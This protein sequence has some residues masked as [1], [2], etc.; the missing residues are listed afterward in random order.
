MA[1]YTARSIKNKGGKI[2]LEEWVASQRWENEEEAHE[3]YNLGHLYEAA[4]AHYQATGKKNL[5]KIALKSAELVLKDFGPGKVMLPPGHQEIEIGLVKLY[6][7]TGEK[8]YLD[9]AK[10]F[11]D[12]RGNSQGHKLYGFY[13]QDHL[14]VTAD[15]SGWT[16]GPGR[17]YVFGDGRGSGL[18]TGDEAYR[19][20][21]IKL[22][23]DVAFRKMY[24]TG[25]IGSTGAWEGFGRPI[26][27]PTVQLIVKLCF[28]CQCF[29]E[30]PHVSSGRGG[31]VS[32]CF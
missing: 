1:F 8:K 21:L 17:L 14:P 20:A 13:S 11:L 25:G 7:L 2:P 5:L 16:C 19:Q 31:Q 27:C 12:Q 6:R 3:L 29:L 26:T 10:F 32:G 24:L 28:D 9:Q 23:E 18:I 4:V 22:W 15:R 30:L